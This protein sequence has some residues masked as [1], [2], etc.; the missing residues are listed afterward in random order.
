MHFSFPEALHARRRVEDA[1]KTTLEQ[2]GIL[3]TPPSY[4]NSRREGASGTPVAGA[5]TPY[6][7]SSTTPASAVSTPR[8]PASRDSETPR[9]VTPAAALL[10]RAESI[11]RHVAAALP[12]LVDPHEEV[13]SSRTLSQLSAASFANAPETLADYNDGTGGGVSE[14]KEDVRAVLVTS[15]VEDSVDIQSA[16]ADCTAL[17]EDEV[18]SN[19][20]CAPLMPVTLI[21][22]AFFQVYRFVMAHLAAS[23]GFMPSPVQ[24]R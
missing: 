1:L 9:A 13:D 17:S 23:G 14:S 3:P 7:F 8:M 19:A 18:C 21:S 4:S 11:L 5:A 6:S 16:V 22:L 2:P 12:D 15:S 20:V 24:V 10:E